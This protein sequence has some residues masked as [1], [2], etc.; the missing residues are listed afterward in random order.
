MFTKHTV[1]I[2]GRVINIRMEEQF[3]EWLRN[4]AADRDTTLSALLNKIAAEV[5]GKLD[6]RRL[7]SILRVYVLE[8]VMSDKSSTASNRLR[9]RHI[10]RSPS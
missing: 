10:V 1:E 5:G 4:I 2:G 6:G 8:E 7:A 9:R 3:W